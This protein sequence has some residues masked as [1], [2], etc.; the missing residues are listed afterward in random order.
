MANDALQEAL[1]LL[2]ESKWAK[3]CVLL[4][5]LKNRQPDCWRM[6]QEVL[7]RHASNHR[8]LYTLAT[9]IQCSIKPELSFCYVLIPG[10]SD[11]DKQ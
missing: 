7:F 1:Q 6:I 3:L 9:V 4:H 10:L 2:H 11:L 8:Q 5:Q